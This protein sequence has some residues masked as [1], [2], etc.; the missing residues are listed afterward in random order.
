MRTYRSFHDVPTLEGL[1]EIV[2]GKDEARHLSRV[3][4]ASPGDRCILVNGRGEEA[5]ATLLDGGVLRIDAVRRAAPPARA[6]AVA[7]ALTRTDAFED[8][9]E[10]CIEL[11]VTAFHPLVTE[12]C[13]V[14]LDAG[15]RAARAERW[16]RLAIERLK[17]CERLHLPSIGEPC[18]LG[19]FLESAPTASCRTIILAERET[20]A[21]R[22]R[23]LV[24][25]DSRDICLLVGPEGGWSAEE[26]SLMRQKGCD[27][28]S[29]GDHI[30]RSETALIVAVATVLAS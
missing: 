1:G 3:R 20:G 21:P 25:A 2:L 27:S 10:R 5:D 29:L 26:R 8:A 11:G 19:D 7:P 6:L 9:L 22:L 14:R 24:A 28:A 23:D 15:K 13:V 4:R 18:E 12:H 30:L 17:Q 16:R